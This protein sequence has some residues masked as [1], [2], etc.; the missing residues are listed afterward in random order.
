M[1]KGVADT[2]AIIWYIYGDARL[3]NPAKTFIQNTFEQGDQIAIS[4]ITLIEV[5]YLIERNRI[6]A[7]SFSRLALALGDPDSGLLECPIDLQTARALSRVSMGQIPDMPDRI[8]AATALQ[9]EVPII[10]RDARITHSDL[11]TIW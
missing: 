9:L 7:E 3:S 6:A 11:E 5:I 8:I 10:S 1:I 4:A 2:H